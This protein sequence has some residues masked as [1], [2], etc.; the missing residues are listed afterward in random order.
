MKQILINLANVLML[1][2]C[3]KQGIDPSNSRVVKD[4]RGFAYSLVDYDTGKGIV[5]V[6]FNK[7][8]TPTYAWFNEARSRGVQG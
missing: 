7:H 2:Y 3:E 6:Q 8:A 5:A 4:G 1:D